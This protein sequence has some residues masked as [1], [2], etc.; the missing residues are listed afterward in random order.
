M[1][2]PIDRLTTPQTMII[3]TNFILGTGILTLPRTALEKVKTPDIW[4]TIIIAGLIS[5][6]VGLIIIKLNEQFPE[7]SFYEYSGE[8][9]GKWMGKI[10]NFL[11][12]SYFLLICGFH[13]RS[14]VM[15]TSYFLLE[16]TPSWAIM[17][18][19]MWLSVYLAVGGINPI[20]RVFEIIFPITVILLLLVLLM[21][22]KLFEVDYIRPFLGSGILPVLHGIRTTSLS[23]T[24]FEI[25]L[26][27]GVFM[28][29]RKKAKKA[30]L[31]GIGIPVVLYIITVILVIGALSIDGVLGRTWPTITLIRSY[32]I[33]GLIF[34]RFDSLFLVVWIMQM[35]ASFNISHYVASLG[36]AKT[37]HKDRKLFV[38]VTLPLIYV[39]AMIPKNVDDVFHL[40]DFVGNIALLLIGVLPFILLVISK[41]KGK[42][43]EEQPSS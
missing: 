8:I 7:K 30:V 29:N 20:A 6:A 12:I 21:S 22:L 33:T 37:T 18:P 10:F 3:C 1:L 31:F 24:G 5:M 32:E 25:F 13:L 43:Y 26:F 42:K 40:G 36:L 15:V 2:R 38:Y 23:F 35:F 41:M 17:M 11:F 39:I 34:E 28:K 27:I 16:G 4:L 19:F 14:L 9:M